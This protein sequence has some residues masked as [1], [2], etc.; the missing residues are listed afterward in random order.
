MS[1]SSSVN[2]YVPEGFTGKLTCSE[3]SLKIP[4]HTLQTRNLAVLSLVKRKCQ[5][6]IATI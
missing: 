1:Y 6:T 3:R 5:Q 2:V 4:P